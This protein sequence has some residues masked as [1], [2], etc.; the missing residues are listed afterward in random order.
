MTMETVYTSALVSRDDTICK[1]DWAMSDLLVMC[2]NFFCIFLMLN[3]LFEN[4]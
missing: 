1:P 4:P 3:D 2:N